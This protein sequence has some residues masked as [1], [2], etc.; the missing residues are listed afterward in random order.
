MNRL[1]ATT[2]STMAFSCMSAQSLTVG[3]RGDCLP[4]CNSILGLY[5]DEITY[6]ISC[7]LRGCALDL[8]KNFSDSH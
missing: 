6:M 2:L 5:H 3:H 8:L 4:G 7:G 1:I